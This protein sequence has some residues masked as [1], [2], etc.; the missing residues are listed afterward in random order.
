M[1]KISVMVAAVL[2]SASVF[3]TG[4]SLPKKTTTVNGSKPKTEIKK[5]HKHG[6]KQ[7]DAKKEKKTSKKSSKTT[8][9][10][11]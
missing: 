1:K 5:E 6:D 4:A 7:K 11:K 2:L 8:A 3:A 9:V 10:K